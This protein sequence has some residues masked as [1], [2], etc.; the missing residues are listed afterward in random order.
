MKGI[1]EYPLTEASVTGQGNVGSP[2]SGRSEERAA[3]KVAPQIIDLSALAREKSCARAVFYLSPRHN[4]KGARQNDPAERTMAP[5]Q[6]VTEFVYV[7]QFERSY[8]L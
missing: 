2:Q 6:S 4:K 7:L 3:S 5:L 1:A 8:F